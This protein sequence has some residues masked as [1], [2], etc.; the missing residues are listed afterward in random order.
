MELGKGSLSAGEYTANSVILGSRTLSHD[1]LR[2]FSLLAL[3]YVDLVNLLNVGAEN[4]SVYRF[5]VEG[6]VCV[7]KSS[8]TES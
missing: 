1:K 4:A 5:I 8:M 6:G 3:A 7:P 2:Y